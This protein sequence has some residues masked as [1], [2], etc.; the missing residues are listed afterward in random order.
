M[1][2]NAAEE[3][4]SDFT[5]LGFRVYRDGRVERLMGTDIVPPSTNPETGVQSKDVVIDPE[6]GLS[7][8]LYI[9]KTPN[10]DHKLPLL[11]YFHGGFCIESAFSPTYQT[12]LNSLAA[13]ANAVVIS[14]DFRR[15]PEHP[16]PI[17]YDDSWAAVKWVASHSTTSGDSSGGNIA[18]NMGIRVGLEGLDGMRLVG[19]VLV[20][21]Y[22]GG[23][24]PIGA[25]CNNI[26]G[27][28]LSHKLWLFVYPSSSG[29]DDPLFNP[30][31]DPKFS[32]LDCKKVLVC[33]AEQDMLKDR[34]WYYKK[35]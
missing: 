27:K 29:H 34:G 8:R 12:Y 31:L 5:L 11:V 19:I 13:K 9:P 3:V 16:L 28:E 14:V 30:V 32:S 10:P 33:V 18:H 17:P 1:A 6:T 20:H 25:E 23:K 35:E 26:F 2:S 4:V 22:F 7:A 24:D 15:A 21:P